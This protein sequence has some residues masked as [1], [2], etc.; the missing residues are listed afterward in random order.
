MNSWFG[1]MH[2]RKKECSWPP[3]EKIQPIF[4]SFHVTPSAASYILSEKGIQ[5]LRSHQPIGCRD[6]YTKEL[7]ESHDI[8][9]WFS[10]CLT[11]TLPARRG[12]SRK[13][14]VFLVD[15][16]NPVIQPTVLK[17]LKNIGIENVKFRTHDIRVG[18]RRPAARLY[19][20]DKLL[21]QYCS[22][23][24][25]VTSRLHCAIPCVSMGIPVLLII[26]DKL[27]ER[28]AG[29]ELGSSIVDL[30]SFVKAPEHAIQTCLE[31]PNGK[32]EYVFKLES[33]LREFLP[34]DSAGSEF[35]FESH[36]R[37][38]R[39]IKTFD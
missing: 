31:K 12:I 27:D 36:W 24:V 6:L 14:H 13:D 22:A 1:H 8:Q 38:E 30:I 2:A 11:A 16:Y 19:L 3:A 20:A 15:L 10:G 28:F 34:V 32:P 5:Y 9:A 33:N 37:P 17:A 39:F 26:D 4:L 25:V 7:L 29:L 21:A 23:K 18:R 35:S